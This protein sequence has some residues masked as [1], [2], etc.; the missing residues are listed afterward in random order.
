MIE[1]L[2][3]ALLPLV[4]RAFRLTKLDRG[5]RRHLHAHLVIALGHV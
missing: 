2:T 5:A 4:A 1:A 3:L